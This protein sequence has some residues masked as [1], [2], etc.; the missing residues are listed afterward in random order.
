MKNIQQGFTLIELM[1]VVTIIGV[2]AAV[3]LP[4]YQDRVA[5]SK[6]AAALG[7]VAS[8]KMGFELAL[9]GGLTPEV[10]NNV[11]QG[12]IGIQASNNNTDA[13]T[14]AATKIEGAIK[15]GPTTVAGKTITLTRDVTTGAW[16]CTSNALQ[17]YIGS[18]KVCVGG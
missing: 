3:A 18:N 10:G 6:F 12:G 13:I 1:I 8:G 17:K 11:L 14:V 16:D 5:R 4:Q 2:L 9:N 7:E 15:G